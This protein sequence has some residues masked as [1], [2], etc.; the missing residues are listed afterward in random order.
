MGPA[1]FQGA[2]NGYGKFKGEMIFGINSKAVLTAIVHNT[3]I[4]SG[5]IYDSPKG[6]QGKSA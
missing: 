6:K 4:S 1:D 5:R 2:R 3:A